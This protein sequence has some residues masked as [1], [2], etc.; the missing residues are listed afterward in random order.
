MNEAMDKV[1][2]LKAEG[3]VVASEEV[4]K[5]FKT[6]SRPPDKNKKCNSDIR[7]SEPKAMAAYLQFLAFWQLSLWK[8]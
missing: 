3:R 4:S 1:W 6:T 7:G 8:L 2:Q 5:T